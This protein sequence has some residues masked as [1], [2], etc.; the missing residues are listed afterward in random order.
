[1]EFLL[2]LPTNTIATKIFAV[3]LL[4]L[5]LRI[6]TNVL[7]PKKSKT[8]PPQA[9][10][11]W[12]LIGHLHLL[13]GPQA[14]YITLSK[15]ADKYGPIFKIKLG[16]HP[17]LVISN[18]EL[19]KECLTTHDKVLANRPATVAMEIMGYNH[20]M[21]GWSPYGPYWRQLRKLVTV[22]LLS[23]QRLKTFKHIRESE[24]KNSLKEMYQ[25][26]VHNKTGDSN[27]VSVDM[28]R[29]F[30]D[31][32]GNLI[33]RIVVG[34][35][36]ARKGEGV[37]RWKLVVGDYMKLL[38]HFN[39]GDAMPFM[40]WFDL[41][42]LE[43]AMKI[44]FKE[45][46]GYVEEWLEEHKKKRSNSGGHGIVE[47]DFMDVMLS[48]FD[49]G[50][51]QEFCTD[52]STHTTNK[53][54]CMAL[55]LGASETTK[56]TLTWSLSLL[57]NNLDVLKKVKQEL[58]AHIGPETLVTES[59]V[60]SLVYLDAVITE[61]LRLYPLGPLGLPHESI[62][63]CTIAGYHV[64]ARTRI[65]FNLWKIHQD[66]RVWENPLEFKPE[67]FLK[68]HNNIDVRGGHF[69]LLPFGS[70][71]R[72]CPGV[73]FALQ[74]LKLTLAN[75]LHGFDFATPNDEPVDMTEV[76]HMAT[77]RATPLETLISPRLP[78][79]LYMG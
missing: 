2:S 52:N 9:G 45:L 47:E 53:A 73:S 5:F 54:M 16:V 49:D 29:I 79:H 14:S 21:F 56:T 11:A 72:M 61:T 23:N 34:K 27:H 35:V 1:M 7:K 78:S 31:I 30:G 43:K 18:S 32:T 19:A 70:G 38:T 24:I 12:P 51:Q 48:I 50:G 17:T 13:I 57:L 67:R 46:D 64:P 59:D 4:Y 15:M 63:D 74:V 36:Y 37:V 40:R 22:E 25:S 42:G 6:F 33:Y 41:G 8:S 75:M 66:P 69:E 28:T 3:L 20:A 39:V 71:R 58:A 44:T 77:T 60:N 68:E 65:L 55:I 10:G 62:E 76:N 26:W